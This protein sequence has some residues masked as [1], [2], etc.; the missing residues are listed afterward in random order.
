MGKKC[1]LASI[2][3]FCAAG[4]LQAQGS[5]T[6]ERCRSAA[7][8]VSRSEEAADLADSDLAERKKLIRTPYLPQAHGY[9]SVFY[10]SDA[11]DP[12]SFTDLPFTLY[13]M[14]K[15]QFHVG[16]FASQIIYAGG[17][18]KVRMDLAEVDS[19]LEKQ[20]LDGTLIQADR[21]VD[22]L[23][24]GILL[25][26]KQEEILSAQKELLERKLESARDAFEAGRIYRTDVLRLE[27]GLSSLGSSIDGLVAER[28]SAEGN[29]AALTGLEIGPETKLELPRPESFSPVDDPSLRSLDLQEQRAN[30]S[31]RL[32]LAKCLPKLSL[33]G[34]MGFGQWSLDFFRH[35]PD[36]YGIVGLG[37]S[38]P[39]TSWQD[40][41]YSRNLR[42][43]AL[44]RIDIQR[45]NLERRRSAELSRYDGSIARYDAMLDGA[46]EAVAKYE[47]LAAEM[48]RLSSG[49]EAPVSEYIDALSELSSAKLE[50]QRL[51]ILR[52]KELLKKGQFT[53]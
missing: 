26:Q 3:L 17:S 38:V 22:D 45:G 14:P 11:P 24:L 44:A 29:L 43:N 5:L 27:A 21:A 32:A 2:L 4:L 41:F 49:G 47:E 31:L 23:F 52:I 46:R 51:I 1:I 15:L 20:S 48:D 50:E 18:R 28:V 33:W 7:R 12:A 53:L 37:I 8:E 36:V 6:L 40:Y 13:P 19:E 9:G 35:D 39:L 34:T 25:M 10:Q 16:V 30:L 42:D